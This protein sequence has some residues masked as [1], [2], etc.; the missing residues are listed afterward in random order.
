MSSPSPESVESA[1]VFKRLW[2]THQLYSTVSAPAMVYLMVL[3]MGLN[4]QEAKTILMYVVPPTLGVL[5]ALLPNLLM[6]RLVTRAFERRPED[7]STDRLER[8]LKIPGQ[9]VVITLVSTPPGIGVVIGAS[10]VLFGRHPAT[11]LWTLV[12]VGLHVLLIM[13]LVQTAV[14][15]ILSPYAV[16]EFHQLKGA[17]VKRSG[18]LWPRQAWF[19]PYSF[20]VFVACTL[21]TTL[22]IVGKQGYNA[23]KFLL[24]QSLG[25]SPDQF[26]QVLQE[27]LTTLAKESILPITVLGGYL[28]LIATVTAWLLARRQ[29]QGTLSI[30]EALEGLASGK[31]K[32]PNWVSTDEIGDLSTATAGVFEQL[33]SLSFSLRDSALSLQHSAH[34]LGLS[35]DKQTEVLSVQATALQET[36]VT[37]EEITQTSQLASKT[38]NN[39]L[40]QAERAQ[41]ISQLGEASIQEG[42]AGLEEI[43]A[44]VREIASSIKSLDEQARQIA[45]ITSMVKDL[46]DQ[47][48]MLALNAA[49]EAV[50]SGESGKGFGVVAKEIRSLADQSIRATHNI[51][52]IL[53]GIGTAIAG[54]SALT[55]KNSQR[56]ESSIKQIRNFSQQVEQL[57]G[58]VG[59][60][61]KSVRQIAA[62]VTQQDAGIVQI[63]QAV[64]DMTRIMDQTMTQLR[65]SEEAISVVRNVAEQVTGFVGQYGWAQNDA[66]AASAESTPPTTP[67]T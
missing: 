11:I 3:I 28:L 44:Q 54:V 53:Q 16:A 65:A 4:G 6:R 25:T 27:S 37:T 41:G 33:R 17:M 14:E 35:T 31:P 51:R 36:Q 18:F 12:S 10:V 39:I 19:L 43:G 34:Q 20:A 49:I 5:S 26:Q 42:M 45:R 63:T 62:A 40:A 21:A 9:I 7:K 64:T 15:G 8:I 13:I 29:K 61:A 32:L 56:V 46:A 24:T 22:T 50:R 59:D 57:S 67:P 60:N 30:Q 47:S 66:A 38:A 58:I 1:K 23:Y 55:Q 2:N 48:N 52:S